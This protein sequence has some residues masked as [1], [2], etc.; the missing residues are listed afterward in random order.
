M[1]FSTNA[2]SIQPFSSDEGDVAAR[3][4]REEFVGEVRAEE[5]A[6][7]D[8]RHPV[9]FEPRL[10]HRIDDRDFRAE[11]LRVVQV[12]HRHGL[13]VRD[14]GAEEDD[15]VGPDPILVRTGRGGDAERV[16]HGRRARRVARPAR[17]VDVVRAD[18]PR[19][20]RRDV[21][22]LVRHAPGGDEERDSV[23][24]RRADPGRRDVQRLL[25]GNPAEARVAPV[26]HHRV[27]KPAEL[28]QV[29]RGHRAERLDILQDLRPEPAHRVQRQEV[30]THGAEVDPLHREVAEARRPEGAAIAHAVPED[31]H[32]QQRATLVVPRGSED[33]AVIV[34]LR[35]AESKRDR[36]H[37]PYALLPPGR[38][39]DSGMRPRLIFPCL[40]R[41]KA[42]GGGPEPSFS[43][44]EPIP[45][46][47]T[48]L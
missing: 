17:V 1:C 8:R 21:V 10:P 28:P 2:S 34:R 3:V 46:P 32:R 30:Q 47:W 13:V 19:D 15:Q 16:L 11:L 42:R 27:G 7:G 24:G 38:S 12:L 23:R 6:A 36:A 14:V 37:A 5:G 4:D 26:P 29:P 9:P 45:R 41:F 39:H 25:P 35:E 18:E 31:A 40:P 44:V 20:L 48:R 22:R 33:F 43:S